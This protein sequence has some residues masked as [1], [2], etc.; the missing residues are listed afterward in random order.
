MLDGTVAPWVGGHFEFR[1][2]FRSGLPLEWVREV[3][4]CGID[5][6]CGITLLSGGVPGMVS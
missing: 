2:E 1:G 6:C 5:R 3:W 4:V